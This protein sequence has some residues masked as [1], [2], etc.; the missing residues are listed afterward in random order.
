MNEVIVGDAD[1]SAL[2]CGDDG[3]E[4]GKPVGEAEGSILGSIL[5][6]LG[7]PVGEADGSILG[8]ILTGR[9][10]SEL[11]DAVGGSVVIHLALPMP[12]S[13]TQDAL[14]SSTERAFHSLR[15]CKNDHRGC[16]GLVRMT[17]GQN[18][19]LLVRMKDS[20]KPWSWL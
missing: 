17:D 8:S 13:T 18:G 4:L 16:I 10:G 6:E 1:G 12:G 7:K 3:T 9:E 14:S 15:Y 5:T 19:L 2:G 11:G 20:R